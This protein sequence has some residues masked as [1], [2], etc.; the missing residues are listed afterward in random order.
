MQAQMRKGEEAGD[1]ESTQLTF[2]AGT[3]EKR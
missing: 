2:Y 1:L 3:T